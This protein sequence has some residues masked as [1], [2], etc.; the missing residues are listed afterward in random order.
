M[1]RYLYLSNNSSL[2][3]FYNFNK[4]GL[5]GGESYILFLRYSRS[6]KFIPSLRSA[7]VNGRAKR[8]RELL[9]SGHMIL[10]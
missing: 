9:L 7:N 2:I 3:Y 10:R 1:L 6:F 8:Y 5:R 4:E